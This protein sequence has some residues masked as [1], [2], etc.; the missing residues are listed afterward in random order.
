MLRLLQAIFSP[1]NNSDDDNMSPFLGP[2]V[3]QMGE[4]N[5]DRK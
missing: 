5:I 1:L 4:I 3:L 2:P